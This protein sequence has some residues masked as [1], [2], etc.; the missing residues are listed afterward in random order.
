[1]NCRILAF[2]LLAIAMLMPTEPVLAQSGMAIA[3]EVCLG[4]HEDVVSPV[5]YGASVHGQNACTSCHVEVTSLDAH[6]SG[7]VM[8]GEPKCVRCHKKETSE[9]YSSV[10]QLNDVS[11]ADCHDDIHT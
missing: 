1:M 9:H 5:A 11:C 6:I 4:C 8:P 10:H 2:L 3:P 7:D